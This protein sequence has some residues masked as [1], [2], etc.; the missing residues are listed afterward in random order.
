MRVLDYPRLLFTIIR[1]NTLL[2][3]LARYC[4]ITDQRKLRMYASAFSSVDR[5]E[6][7]F[8]NELELDFGLRSINKTII[9]DQQFQYLKLILDIDPEQ[10]LNLRLFTVVAALS[11]RVVSLDPFISKSFMMLSKT[12]GKSR[13]LYMLMSRLG[14]RDG[15]VPLR[16]LQI[17]MKSGSIPQEHMDVLMQKFS[18]SGRYAGKQSHYKVMLPIV[19]GTTLIFSTSSHTAPCS[20]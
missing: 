10:K 9:S 11:E 13:E 1:G 17:E 16:S 18:A 14:V 2:D 7:G 19:A 4:I 5:D 8:I 15:V 3:F 20:I 6:D 12:V